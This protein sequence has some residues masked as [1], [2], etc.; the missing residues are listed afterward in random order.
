LSVGENQKVLETVAGQEIGEVLERK[1]IDPVFCPENRSAR[2]ND[3]PAAQSLK[4]CHGA[5]VA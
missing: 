4:I 3:D 1:N 5:F 2:V